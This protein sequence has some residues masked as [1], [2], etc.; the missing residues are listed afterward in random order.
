[1][2]LTQEQLDALYYNVVSYD[3]ALGG[4]VYPFLE[5]T[6]R[7]WRLLTRPVGGPAG[8]EVAYHAAHT[9]GRDRPTLRWVNG[10]QVNDLYVDG[11][12]TEEFL[13]TTGLRLDLHQGAFVLSK[14]LSRL[15]RPH[16]VS[17]FFAPEEVRIAYM[18]QDEREAKIWDGAGL[19]SRRMLAALLRKMVLSEGLSPQKRDALLCELKQAGRVEFTVMTPAGQ[20]KG[21]AVRQALL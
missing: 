5:A 8:E 6:G 17:G 20:D 18:E 15:M 3:D 12:D 9:L 2:F 11:M 16:F 14:R 7:A 4:A 19:I 10:E 1:M 13:A 21:H